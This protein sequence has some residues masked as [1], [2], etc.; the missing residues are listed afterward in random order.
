[1]KKVGKILVNLNLIPLIVFDK[2]AFGTD[3]VIFWF[4]SG[5]VSF[6]KGEDIDE[7]EFERFR[8]EL[9]NLME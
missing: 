8:K 5:P 3:R 7:K 4:P 2:D 6:L 9:E 1:M